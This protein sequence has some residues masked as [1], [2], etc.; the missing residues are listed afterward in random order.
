MSALH[1]KR[2]T[3]VLVA[4][5]V[6]VTASGGAATARATAPPAPR[7]DDPTRCLFEP[8]GTVNINQADEAKLQLLPGVGPA[9]ARA[10][11][12]RRGTRPFR[13]LGEL[14][15]VKGFG[16]RTFQRI[17]PYVALEGPTTLARRPKSTSTTRK[18]P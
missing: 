3:R 13:N 16:P 6:F 15:R 17:K 14:R 1:R 9:R 4:A 12:E 7:T 5:A 11:V 8:Q 10:I 2:L 18:E